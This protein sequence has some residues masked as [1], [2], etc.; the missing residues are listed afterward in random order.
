MLQLQYHHHQ[1]QMGFSL[2]RYLLQP[3]LFSTI[4][5][6]KRRFMT[7]LSKFAGSLRHRGLRKMQFNS[8]GSDLSLSS[9]GQT[10][11]TE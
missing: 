1:Q 3:F 6:N 8:Q 9:N 11:I 4:E 2:V 5:I 7:Y 10:D